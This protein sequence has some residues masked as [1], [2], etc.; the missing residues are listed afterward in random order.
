MEAINICKMC[1][2]TIEVSESRT[3][4]TC[5]YCGTI[6]TLPRL[7]AERKANMYERASHFRRNNEFDKAMA[8]YEQILNE[9]ITDA[10]SYWSLVL[11]R[12]GVEYVDDPET[13]KRIPTVNRTHYTSIFADEDYKSTLRYADEFQRPIYESEAKTFNEIQKE[14]IE[15]SRNEEPYDAYICCKETNAEGGLTQESVVAEDL[16]NQLTNAGFRVFFARVTLAS[17]QVKAAE[18]Y[19]FSA[20]SSARV[21]VVLGTRPDHFESPWVKNEWSRFLGMIKDD[22]SKT[23]IP[24][25]KDMDHHA[26]PAEFSHLTPRDMSDQGF[27]QYVISE[28]N[29][30]TSSAEPAATVVNVFGGDSKWSSE[31]LPRLIQNGQTSLKLGNYEAATEVY[32]TLTRDYPEEH[33]GWWGLMVCKTRSF[34]VVDRD[35]STLNTW[36]GY[37]RKLAEPGDLSELEKTY[38]DYIRKVTELTA[39]DEVKNVNDK[40]EGYSVDVVRSE[41]QITSLAKRKESSRRQ[42]ASLADENKRNISTQKSAVFR[43]S[44][45]MVFQIILTVIGIVAVIVGGV[46]ATGGGTLIVGVVAVVVGIVLCVANIRKAVNSSKQK[47]YHRGLLDQYRARTQQIADEARQSE[48]NTN[49]SIADLQNH[50]AE[51]KQ[52]IVDCHSYLGLGTEKIFDVCFARACAEIGVEQSI[53]EQAASLRTA[54]FG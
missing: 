35:V 44:L 49:Q 28:I 9:D 12:Y 26:L 39:E 34:T 36:F 3:I 2:G 29:K 30:A 46:M 11:C 33:K 53:D 47:K 10:E 13:H 24:A 4:G 52:K 42:F 20:L 37:I 40:I 31:T 23:L 21:M 27:V 19:I 16:Y 8:I 5:E 17:K 32:T 15:I 18:P 51:T 7:D 22:K 45:G 48:M 50:I 1:G 43:F 41:S 6:Q 14:V 54:V 25:Y 38:V